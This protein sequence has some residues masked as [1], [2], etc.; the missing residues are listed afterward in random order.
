MEII[1]YKL[2]D[3]LIDLS[4]VPYSP[5]RDIRFS[6]RMASILNESREVSSPELLHK[7]KSDEYSS[8]IVRKRME[9]FGKTLAELGYVEIDRYPS[10][11]QQLSEETGLIVQQLH[12]YRRWMVRAGNLQGHRENPNYYDEVEDRI[13]RRIGAYVKEGKRAKEAVRLSILEELGKGELEKFDNWWK[14]IL[15]EERKV[16]RITKRNVRNGDK[17]VY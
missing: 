9:R 10:R 6:E 16:R 8:M 17:K 14:R 3:G 11:V 4:L 12:N 2:G 7:L 1:V 13:L 15:K 5:R